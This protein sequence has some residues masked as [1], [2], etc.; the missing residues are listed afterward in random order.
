[1]WND[2]EGNHKI[3]LAK[4]PSICMKKDFGG[5]G[6]PNLQDLNICLIGDQEIHQSEGAL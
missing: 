6:I 4:W 2:E 5:L 3:H 1:M